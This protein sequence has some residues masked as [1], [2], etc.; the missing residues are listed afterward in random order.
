MK[1]FSGH[2]VPSRKSEWHMPPPRA[3][4]QSDI[5]HPL[6]G[7]SKLEPKVCSPFHRSRARPP[8]SLTPRSFDF[9]RR[10]RH[11]C[12]PHSPFVRPSFPLSNSY[13]SN[14]DFYGNDIERT[15]ERTRART[16]GRF[17][18]RTMGIVVQT[19][20]RKRERWKEGRSLPC[21]ILLGSSFA[22]AC[23]C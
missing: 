3:A 10:L 11:S 15:A 16:W 19:T 2:F 14:F 17:R 7:I 23:S 18:R 4:P 6:K 5:R 8:S 22:R 21:K 20:E 1:R 9:R 12:L 13:F